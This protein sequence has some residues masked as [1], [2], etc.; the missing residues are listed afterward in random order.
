MSFA[1]SNDQAMLSV[2]F[3]QILRSR[4]GKWV[5]WGVVKQGAYKALLLG[6][7]AMKATPVQGNMLF[8]VPAMGVKAL[9]LAIDCRRDNAIEYTLA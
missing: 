7:R 4:L 1:S 9:A 6:S 3:T 2:K 8:S 5:L